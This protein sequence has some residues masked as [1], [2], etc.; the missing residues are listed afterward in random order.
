MNAFDNPEAPTATSVTSQHSEGELPADLADHHTHALV[1]DPTTQALSL[2]GLTKSFDGK[3]VVH[4]LSL[5]VPRGSFFGVVGPN[6]A[7][8]TTTLTMATGLLRP[9]SGEAYLAGV[10]VWQDLVTAKQNYGLVAD[11]LATFDRLTGSELLELTGHLHGLDAETIATRSRQLLEVFELADATT[12]MVVD[13]SAGMTKKILVACALLHS[14]QLL[15]LDEPFESVDPVSAQIIKDILGAYVATGGT[16][17]FSSH[18]ME[19]VEALC[20]HVAVVV[21]GQVVAA[22]PLDEVRAGESLTEKF[23]SLA[24]GRRQSGGLDWLA[25]SGPATPAATQE[26]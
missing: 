6:G 22:G 5:D 18:V 4:D 14:P 7:G 12:T 10:N 3:Q 21:R 23:F 20:D 9:D 16:V 17:V 19:L 13:Y 8:K 24:G 11:N 26:G 25:G 15:I 2:R 1:A